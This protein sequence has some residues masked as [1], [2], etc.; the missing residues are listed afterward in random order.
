MDKKL[1][2]NFKELKISARNLETNP[3]TKDLFSAIFAHTNTFFIG[4][5]VLVPR[6]RGG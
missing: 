1:L 6:S 4:E 5:T 3:S 2:P